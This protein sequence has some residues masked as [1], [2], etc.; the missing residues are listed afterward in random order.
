MRRIP[1]AKHTI[2]ITLFSLVV[3]L[4]FALSIYCL[5]GC[6][7][8]QSSTASETEPAGGAAQEGSA[9]EGESGEATYVE[10]QVK[11]LLDTDLLWSEGRGDL[12]PQGEQFQAAT[13]KVYDLAAKHGCTVV[14]YEFYGPYDGA[15][16]I[17]G[18]PAG[19]DEDEAV[20]EFL[21]EPLIY[22]AYRIEVSE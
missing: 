22:S 17:M 2:N 5:A 14:D 3:L 6:G 13:K 21:A 18:L 1:A 7:D 20:T 4:L 8:E 10:G 12:N 19:K 16:A 9:P 11:V 15:M